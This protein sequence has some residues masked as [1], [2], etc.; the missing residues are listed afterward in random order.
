[1]IMGW[2]AGTM[3]VTDPGLLEY[4][5]S[6]LNEHGNVFAGLY[7]GA[8]GVCAV[9]VVGGSQMGTGPTIQAR[10]AKRTAALIS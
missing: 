6:M 7:Y 5:P 2:I 8:G 10:D 9:G 3:V 1:M 4:L